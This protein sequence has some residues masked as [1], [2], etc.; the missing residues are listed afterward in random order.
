MKVYRI[1][2][3]NESLILYLP[4][5]KPSHPSAL[6]HPF[7]LQLTR[8]RRVTCRR[9]IT[10]EE[11]IEKERVLSLGKRRKRRKNEESKGG[12]INS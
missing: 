1:M 8:K 10:E 11:E 2:R 9:I 4:H 3:G 6:S 7:P 12:Q 5:P